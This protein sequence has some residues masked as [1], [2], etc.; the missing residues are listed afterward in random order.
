MTSSKPFGPNP[1]SVVAASGSWPAL[2]QHG[3][4]ELPDRRIVI[5]DHYLR[6]VTG[7]DAILPAGLDR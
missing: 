4:E 3:T 7:T 1:S 5:E 6:H 2:P